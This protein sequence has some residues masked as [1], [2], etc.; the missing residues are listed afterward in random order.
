MAGRLWKSGGAVK[1]VWNWE[2]GPDSIQRGVTGSPL[3]G[4]PG[5]PPL[6]Y[7]PLMGSHERPT[8]SPSREPTTI[9]TT[10]TVVPNPMKCTG[11]CN[12]TGAVDGAQGQVAGPWGPRNGWWRRLSVS[13]HRIGEW[14]TF[15]EPST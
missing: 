13:T 7:R 14:Q 15:C 1:L 2:N 5:R 10:L 11:V 3:K 9:A 4:T 6:R 12:H 8:P